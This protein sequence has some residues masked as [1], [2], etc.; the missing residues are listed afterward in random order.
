[1]KVF[2]AIAVLVAQALCS[3][4]LAQSQKAPVVITNYDYSSTQWERGSYSIGPLHSDML[5]TLNFAFHNRRL[6]SLDVREGNWTVDLGKGLEGLGDAF[7]TR[8]QVKIYSV[9]A[10][11]SA[12]DIGIA[13]PF[14]PTE[15]DNVDQC[16][17]KT[18][19]IEN[20]K[21]IKASVAKASPVRCEY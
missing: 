9:D 12:T 11:G 10:R 16:F 7:P 18:F 2:I 1:M 3:T 14:E 6:E 20:G 21:L 5:I 19:E 17:S 4:A 8:I 15:G 13:L